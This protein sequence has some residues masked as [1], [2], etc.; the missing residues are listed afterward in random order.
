M[1][2]SLISLEA[3]AEGRVSCL[4]LLFSVVGSGQLRVAQ[5]VKR[6]R[7]GRYSI[8]FLMFKMPD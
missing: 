7:A 6:R 2:F 4:T 8:V 3:E 5:P 1:L